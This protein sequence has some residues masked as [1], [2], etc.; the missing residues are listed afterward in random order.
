LLDEE[1]LKKK[2]EQVFTMT[3]GDIIVKE[4]NANEMSANDLMANINDLMLYKKFKPDVVIADYILIMNANDKRLDRG[5]TYSY[6]KTVS[7]ELRN[8]GKTLY[9]PILTA[10]QMNREAMGDRGGSKA[11][12]TSKN[13]SE[14]RGIYDTVDCFLT[15]NQTPA[16]R[17]LN[18]MFLYFDKNRNER[19][20]IKIE[21]SVDYEK[22]KL[23]ERGLSAAQ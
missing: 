23:V 5:N 13:I 17:K 4:Y 18:K 3:E 12:T 21:Y 14:S 15:L 1:G 9:I 2:A 19:T 22:M 6:F 10:C 16:D 11:I 20:S 7:E 8:I